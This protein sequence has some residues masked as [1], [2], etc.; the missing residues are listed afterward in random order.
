ML[1]GHIAH[2]YL[3]CLLLLVICNCSCLLLKLYMVGNIPRMAGMS[4]PAQTGF[5]PATNMVQVYATVAQTAVAA[6]LDAPKVVD[7]VGATVDGDAAE[8]APTGATAA[9]RAASSYDVEQ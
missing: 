7:L 1:K 4:C 5:E 3:L 6:A 8:G 9:G 2:V